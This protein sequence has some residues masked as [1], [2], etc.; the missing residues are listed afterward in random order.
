LK[1]LLSQ[2]PDLETGSLPVPERSGMP[3][4]SVVIPCYNEERTIHLL[5]EALFRQTFK[6]SDLE[7]IISDGLSTDGT[8]NEIASFHKAHPNLCIRVVDNPQRNIPSGLNQAIRAAEGTYIVRLDAHSVPHPDYIERSV[9]ALEKGL[10]ENVGGVW[11]I[12]PASPGW[13]SRSIALA[14]A[15]PLGVGDARYRYTDRPQ[16]VDTVPFGAFRRSLIDQIGGFDETLLTNEDYEFNVRVRQNGGL[17]WLD[18]AIR[19]IYF[20]RHTL[21][22][23]ARQYWRYG[24][25]KARMLARYPDTL[26]WRQALP[27]AFVGGLL[28][29]LVVS[30]WLPEAALFLAAVLLVYLTVLA[31]TAAILALHKKDISLFFG[32]PLA[33][34]VMHFAWGTAL[35]WS[36]VTLPLI[37]SRQITTRTK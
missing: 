23:L 22:A 14:A 26:R 11:E 17:V 10:G 6:R 31:G 16:H 20:P 15:H 27:P 19:S 13:V 12:R 7:V 34:C 30:F 25:W 29:L 35:L 9:A 2:T 8:R 3:V 4:V 21:G 18:P 1:P 33:I 32:V 37:A 28:F 24:Y 36:L 5:L